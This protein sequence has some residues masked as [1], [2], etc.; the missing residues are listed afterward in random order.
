MRWILR[1]A[2]FALCFSLGSAAWY[3]LAQQETTT[4]SSSPAPVVQTAP[5]VI[6]ANQTITPS[7]TAPPEILPGRS[8]SFGPFKPITGYANAPT[9][10][11]RASA[12]R[13]APIVARVQQGSYEPLEIIG[14]TA[15]FLHVRVVLNSGTAQL[16]TEGRQEYTGWAT[17]DSVSP[18]MSAI[19][20]DTETGAVVSRVPL[21]DG[22][23]SVI[24]SPDGSRALFTSEQSGVSQIAYEVRTSDYTLTRSLLSP[25]NETFSALF[26]APASGDLYARV[27]ASQKEN[28][29]RLGDGG[30]VNGMSDLDPNLIVSTDGR[31]GLVARRE[32]GDAPTELTIEMLDLTTLGVRNTFKIRG[33]NLPD[34]G[35]GL[36]LSSDGAKLYLRPSETSG[37]ISVLDTRNGQL[38]S[39]LPGSATAGWSY[40]GRDSILGDSVLLKVWNENGDEMHDAPTRYWIS[41][42]KRMLAQSGIDYVVEAGGNRYAV[43]E[44]GT[45]LLKLNDNNRIQQRFIISR[46][47]RRADA[48]MGNE[49]T[50]FG[51]SASPDGKRLIVFMGMASG[52]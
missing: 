29:V 52:C 42:G 50:V 39:L 5:V 31:V 28:L 19:V 17:W 11:L 10:I 2:V 41:N 6:E 32:A 51:I 33:E 34:N 47:D 4:T 20:I 43:N 40:F 7:E 30:A 49:L 36:V 14:A 48:T 3:V 23:A 8:I 1:H 35:S 44:E 9:L 37:E 15:E 21:T 22:L 24:Y 27:Y 46:P 26:Y 18:E 12:D 25:E 13:N 45:Q 16:A 38:L